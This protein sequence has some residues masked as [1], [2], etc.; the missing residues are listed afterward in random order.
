MVWRRTGFTLVELLVVIAIIGLLVSLLLPAVLASREAA[1]RMAC[2]NN[3]KQIALATH[4]YHDQ[5]RCFPSGYIRQSGDPT[6]NRYK[7]GW[8]WGALI[9]SQLGEQPLYIRLQVAFGVDPLSQSAI[10]NQSL[11]TWRCPSDAVTG[12]TCVPRVQENLNPPLPTPQN[13]NPTNIRRSCL[14]FAARSS[15]VG[16]FGSA[17]VGA[18]AKGNGLFFVNSHLGMRNVTDGTSQTLLAGERRVALGQ[19]TWVGVHWGESMPGIIFDPAMIQTYAVDSLVLGSAH[20]TPN[21]RSNDSRAFGSRH[22]GNFVN[23][24]RVDGGVISVAR[25]IDL[26]VWKS[27]ATLSGGEP[28]PY[29]P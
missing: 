26:S 17:A 12:L 20:T 7:I 8:G 14:G 11:A 23:M 6:E 4:N 10:R 1:L 24:A 27:M 3:L 18:G 15:Y 16:S 19:S 29:T 25:E 28:V 5:Y 22:Y 2:Q 13:P 9:Q 21:P